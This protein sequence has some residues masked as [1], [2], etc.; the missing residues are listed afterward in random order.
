MSSSAS[1]RACGCRDRPGEG[2]NSSRPNASRREEGRDCRTRC[3]A[4]RVSGK[5]RF[6]IRLLRS[7]ISLR[8]D[9]CIPPCPVG[10]RN[11][12]FF[13]ATSASSRLLR[14]EISLHP[15]HCIPSC[16]AESAISASSPRPRRLQDYYAVKSHYVPTIASRLAQSNLQS[17][18]LHRDLGVFKIITQ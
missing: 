13:T 18:H 2:R 9:H 17:R 12:G 1:R 11:L 15:D 3:A 7:E 5:I 14:S 8:P 6:Q 4:R 10:P 16:P